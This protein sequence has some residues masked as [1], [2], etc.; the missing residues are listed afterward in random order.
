MLASILE[1]GWAKVA[2]LLYWLELGTKFR[3]RLVRLGVALKEGVLTVTELFCEGPEAFVFKDNSVS[4]EL[5]KLGIG[6]RVGHCSKVGVVKDKPLL[7]P[8]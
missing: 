4:G 5:E 8:G 7:R 6:V 1:N 3:K 2:P